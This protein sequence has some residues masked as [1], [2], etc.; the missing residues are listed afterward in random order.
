MDKQPA[1]IIE[2]MKDLK[3]VEKKMEQNSMRILEYSSLCSTE[4]PKFGSVEEQTKQ[5]RELVQS[6]LDLATRYMEI[7]RAIER[8]NLATKVVFNDKEY[9]VSDL[10]VLKRK[11]E[12]MIIKTYSSLSD[13]TAKQRQPSFQRVAGDQVVTVK[14]L[15]D[16][17]SKYEALNKWHE[18]FNAITGRLEVVNATTNLIW[19]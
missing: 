2:G 7:K 12:P 6:N 3:L 19:D 13:L 8:T 4:Q 14:Q 17:K 11:L 5:V 16:E 9:T 1:T 18:L 10:L 15:Y